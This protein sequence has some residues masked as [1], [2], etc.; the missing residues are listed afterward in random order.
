MSFE[1]TEK[2]RNMGSHAEKQ[3]YKG[4]YNSVAPTILHAHQ[5]VRLPIT[6]GSERWR[7][8]SVSLDWMYI[9]ASY[10]FIGF[11]EDPRFVGSISHN[12]NSS[13]FSVAP[14]DSDA[15][16]GKRL[17]IGS[18]ILVI[19]TLDIAPASASLTVQAF[20][21]SDDLSKEILE[22][23]RSNSKALANG[24]MVSF[25][26]SFSGATNVAQAVID[27]LFDEIGKPDQVGDGYTL[28][29]VEHLQYWKRPANK[30]HWVARKIVPFVNETGDPDDPHRE[31]YFA[32]FE[33]KL[34]SKE[35]MIGEIQ[36]SGAMPVEE[37]KPILT[38]DPMEEDD[39]D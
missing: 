24:A 3:I 19:D 39:E 32:A 6:R 20:D 18:T 2:F 34:E 5:E 1:S 30:T 23:F 31:I 28:F 11:D 35:S 13:G 26:S 4:I 27:R 38:V 36:E 33:L 16:V 22:E 37:Q 9:S 17:K 7:K 12:G 29:N 8:F 15:K 21:T 10:E 25:G 14:S